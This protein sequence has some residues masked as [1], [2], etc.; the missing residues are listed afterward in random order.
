MS[1]KSKISNRLR[2]S[3]AVLLIAA[4]TLVGLIWWF[5]SVRSYDRPAQTHDEVELTARTSSIVIPTSISLSDIQAKINAAVPATLYSIDENMNGCAPAKMATICIIPRSKCIKTYI[6]P[7]IDCH[8]SGSATLRGPISARA[9]GANLTLAVPVNVDVKAQG[10]GAIGKNIQK[11]AG[12]DANLTATVKFDIDEDWRPKIEISI[13]NHWDDPPHV[14]LFGGKI[15]FADKVD[16]KIN[17]LIADLQKR[18]PGMVAD[19]KLKEKIQEQWNKAFEPSRLRD[20]PELWLSFSPQR[21]GYGGYEIKDGALKMTFMMAGT[22][23][24]H[25]GSKP[26]PQNPSPLPKLLRELPAS[27]FD[28]SLALSADYTTLSDQIKRALKVGVSQEIDVSGLGKVKVTVK[29]VAIYQSLNRALAIGLTLDAQPPNSFSATKGTV[30]LVSQ[31][32]VD[33]DKKILSPNNLAIYSKTDNAPVDLLLSLVE[34]GPI[35]DALRKALTYDFSEKYQQLLQLANDSLN[36]QMSPDFYLEGHLEGMMVEA[37]LAG[38][39][40]LTAIV[41]ARGQ[42][43]I[44]SGHKP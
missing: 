8:L 19:L 9:S 25:L 26:E 16:P 33:N 14:W 39:T 21:V 15:S 29:D 24:T 37:I 23:N 43:A 44:R 13:A 42:L 7:A 2:R 20:S 38:P 3:S 41:N 1:S 27:G 40:A 30:W 34:L 11:T 22:V 6:T 12:A 35:N 17:E 28:F 36:R 18:L 32:G 5:W 10:R 4:L 31:F